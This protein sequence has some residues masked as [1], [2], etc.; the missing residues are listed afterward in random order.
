MLPWA[1]AGGISRMRRHVVRSRG[2]H[3][4]GGSMY[5][6]AGARIVRLGYGR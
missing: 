3:C 6:G 5:L 1:V 4:Q 2:C